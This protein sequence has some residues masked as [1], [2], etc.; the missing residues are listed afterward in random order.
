MLEEETGLLNH[1]FDIET[2]QHPDSLSISS[3]GRK[4]EENESQKPNNEFDVVIPVDTGKTSPGHSNMNMSLFLGHKKYDQ[5]NI[6][7]IFNYQTKANG[8][9]QCLYLF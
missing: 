6:Y 2:L 8:S 9:M 1:S 4:K 7:C 3:E 5:Q